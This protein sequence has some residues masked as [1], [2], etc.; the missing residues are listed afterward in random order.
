MQTTQFGS[1]SSSAKLYKETIIV[2][3][4]LFTSVPLNSSNV[5]G[6]TVQVIN[7][8]ATTITQAQSTVAEFVEKNSLLQSHVSK[9]FVRLG[10][11]EILGQQDLSVNVWP[12]FPPFINVLK[13]FYPSAGV[14]ICSVLPVEDTFSTPVTRHRVTL[15]NSWLYALCDPENK[16]YYLNF[17]VMFI[18]QFGK[19]YGMFKDNVFLNKWGESMLLEYYKKVAQNELIMIV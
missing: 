9:I 19:N 18:N 15:L 8:P 7:L 14:F 1:I 12:M 11:M 3:S 13:Q 16:I 17:Y 2:I 5:G 10:T 4:D 6:G